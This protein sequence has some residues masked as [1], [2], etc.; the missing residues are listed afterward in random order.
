MAV[1]TL[2]T[3][4]T[5]PSFG[6]TRQALLEAAADV[7]TRVGFRQA[8]IR[9]ICQRAG[10]NVA[11]IN[12]HFGDKAGL[13]SEVLTTEGEL[14][15]RRFPAEAGVSKQASPEARL[16]AFI[17]SF[18]QRVLAED[19][20]N[21]HGRMMAREMVE[22]TAAL[23]R[24]VR[25]VIQPQAN[26]LATIVRALLPPG[27]DQTTARLCGLS[28]VG[29]ILFYAHCRPVITRLEPRRAYDLV[30]L[31]RLTSHITRFSLAALREFSRRPDSP[32][33]G[34]R[35]AASSRRAIRSKR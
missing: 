17:R 9:E 3:E 32:A 33:L 23:D 11:A 35:R 12:Y 24:L 1:A 14:A 31:D 25:E 13:Y 8:T 16:T 34:V 5:G 2:R 10:A 19:L 6:A 21:R 4:G 20:A 22:P 26:L 28:I 29:Q 15:Q 18:L 27:T 30:E 7:F